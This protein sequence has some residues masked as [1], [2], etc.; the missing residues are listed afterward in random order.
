MIPEEFPSVGI[1]LYPAF[2][3][4]Q[5]VPNTAVVIILALAETILATASSLPPSPGRTQILISFSPQTPEMR[6]SFSGAFYETCP[7]MSNECPEHCKL[8]LLAL[9]ASPF[10]CFFTS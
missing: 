8:S 2:I 6:V 9:I 4:M 5:C 10:V 7:V 1:T 3:K